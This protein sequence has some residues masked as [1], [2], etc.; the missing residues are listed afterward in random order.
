MAKTYKNFINGQWVAPSTG[1]Y[2]ENRNPAN[3]DDLIGRRQQRPLQR[4]RRCCHFGPTRAVVGQ[5]LGLIPVHRQ[6]ADVPNHRQ[7]SEDAK[8]G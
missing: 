2:F 4:Q 5:R 8:H 3:T 6:G 7:H 1:K